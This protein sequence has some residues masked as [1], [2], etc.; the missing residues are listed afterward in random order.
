ME[1]RSR[2]RFLALVALIVALPLLAVPSG[3]A[4]PSQGTFSVTGRLQNKLTPSVDELANLGLPIQ[5]I[6]VMFQSGRSIVTRTFPGPLLYDVIQYAQPILND[7]NKN[8]Q[9]RFYVSATGFDDYRAIVAWGEFD[10]GF[11]GKE[12]LLAITEDGVSL[13]DQGPRLV[14]PGDKRGGRYVT[15]IKTVRLERG[16]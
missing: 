16:S 5:E 7:K 11:E 15:G 6:T 10:P 4:G 14:V 2:V 3:L 13:A 12:I 1:G 8:D 9:L